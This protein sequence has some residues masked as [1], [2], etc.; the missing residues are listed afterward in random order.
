MQEW[1]TIQMPLPFIRDS[2]ES[3]NKECDPSVTALGQW[4]T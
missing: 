4:R 2:D 1:M 3:S